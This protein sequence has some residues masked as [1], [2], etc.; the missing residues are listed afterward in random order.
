M[1]SSHTSEFIVNLAPTGMVPTR[2]SSP[3]VPL[4]PDEI[5]ADVLACAESGITSVHL[6]ARD[7]NGI[8]THR[9]D[10][11]ARI[12]G[13]IREKR[14]DLVIGVSCSGRM[15]ATLEQRTEVLG[16]EGDLRPDMASLTL[17]SLNFPGGANIN[18]PE[19]VRHLASEMRSRGIKPEFE[20]FDLG[21][22]NVLKYM[23]DRNLV[24][25]PF[26]ANLI[27]GNLASAQAGF[28]DIGCITAALP[29]DTTYCLGGIGRYQVSVAGM[30]VAAAPGVR[31]GLE[32]N[33]WLDPAQSVPASNI[34]LIRKVHALA[35]V[36]DRKIMTPDE[37][38]R[39]LHLRSFQ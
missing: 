27:L 18:S 15:G 30:A 24:D 37:L 29:P 6:H 32:D 28:L 2:G 39:R 38:R 16:L 12:I 34:A 11:Y 7:E 14:P 23:V 17:S 5:V 4:Q 31:I 33:I 9:K 36:H 3:S 10:I 25:P 22:V 26:H 20:I 1:S 19:T 35:E 13:G 21:M 8:P